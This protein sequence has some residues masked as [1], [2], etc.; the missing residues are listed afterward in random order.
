ML[1]LAHGRRLL[2]EQTKDEV[3]PGG[4]EVRGDIP[5]RHGPA[6]GRPL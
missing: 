6:T 1:P 5:R 3:L 4:A 2:L